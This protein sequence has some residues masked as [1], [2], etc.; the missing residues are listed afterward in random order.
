MYKNN[1]LLIK[2]SKEAILAFLAKVRQKIKENPTMKQELLIRNLNPKIKGWV[3][4][5]RFNVSAKA[6]EYVD[7]QIW[8]TLWQWTKRR[9]KKKSRKWIAAKYWHTV[10]RHTWTFGSKTKFK[11]DNGENYYVDLHIRY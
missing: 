4:F 5:H 8:K 10:G 1:K 2:P 9:H 3:N 6:F 7:F 11:L